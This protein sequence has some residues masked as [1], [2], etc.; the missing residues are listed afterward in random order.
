MRHTV[1]RLVDP[2]KRYLLFEVCNIGEVQKLGFAGIMPVDLAALKRDHL[3]GHAGDGILDRG[4]PRHKRFLNIG[5]GGEMR[6][7]ALQK[8]Q[9]NAANLNAELFLHDVRKQRRETAELGVTEAVRRTRLSLGNKAA[10][11]IMD[12]LR[13]GDH[14]VAALLVDTRDVGEKLLHI[15]V[16]FGQINEVG[17]CAVLCGKRRRGRQPA[18][19]A[20]HDLDDADHAGIIDARVL[21]DLHAARCNI[22]GGGGIAGAVVGAEQ[23]VVDRLGHAHD[24]A[25][26]SGLLHELG[27][28]V[29]GVHRVVPAVIEEITNVMLFENLKNALVVRVILIGIL[30][31]IAAGAERGGGGILEKL[32][33]PGILLAHV[34]QAVVQNALDP[35]LRAV[36]VRDHVAVKRGTD[37]PVGTRVDN[38]S[39]TAGLPDDTCAF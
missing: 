35:V 14:A 25:L 8:A 5:L 9:L 13:H 36:N 23:V 29:A 18:G 31:L 26:V 19:V 1:V 10:V 7:A 4:F 3:V 37:H 15:K 6:T 12:A 2:V 16:C 20:S 38:R 21:I 24:P 39:R 28:L 32:Q 27:N 33:L 11:G 17:T 22:L 30:H 34:E